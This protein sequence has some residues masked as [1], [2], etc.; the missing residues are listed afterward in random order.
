VALRFHRTPIGLS[1][2]RRRICVPIQAGGT[3]PVIDRHAG[4]HLLAQA[5]PDVIPR[6]HECDVV[7]AV[8]DVDVVRHAS[9][10]VVFGSGKT[11]GMVAVAAQREA[12]QKEQPE[13]LMGR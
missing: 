6:A 1:E 13:F 5:M 2:C 10:T 4:A 11:R 7:P 12:A 8:A 9:P 3:A